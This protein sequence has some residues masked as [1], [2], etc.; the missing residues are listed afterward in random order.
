MNIRGDSTFGAAPAQIRA[1]ISAIATMQ[2]MELL[3]RGWDYVAGDR[4][5]FLMAVLKKERQTRTR[6]SIRRKRRSKVI[7][8]RSPTR[9]RRLI[10]ALENLTGSARGIEYPAI[11][12]FFRAHKISARE[13]PRWKWTILHETAHLKAPFGTHHGEKF[14]QILL[15]LVRKY[16]LP[17]PGPS[18]GRPQRLKRKPELSLPTR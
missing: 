7:L 12:K 3:G 14:K 18:S 8:G 10:F 6:I 5:R 4:I 17:P 15:R 2:S 11:R 9:P 1:I 16:L 13:F